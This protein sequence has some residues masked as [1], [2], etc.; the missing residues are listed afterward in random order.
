MI[1]FLN[2]SKSFG[3][4]KVL[5]DLNLPV[6]D[7]KIT[8]IM[9]PSGSGKSV[10]LKLLMGFIKPDHGSILFD[11]QDICAMNE[12]ALNEARQK[13]GILFQEAALFDYMNVF[14]NVSFPLYEHTRLSDS[15]IYDKV[16]RMLDEVG[17]SNI[18]HK[19]PSELS[20][21]MKKRVGL[22]RALMLDPKVILFDEPTTGLDPIT[23]MQIGDLIL[24]TQKAR[25]ATVILVNHD[26]SLTYRVADHVGMLYNGKIVELCKPEHLCRSKHPFVQQFLEAQS[27]LKDKE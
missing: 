17:L 19:Y 11:Q 22:A 18:L 12:H 21:G 5:D 1:E 15:M 6:L 3:E 26:L 24:K 14:E 20:G 10:T 16:N 23:T 13:F 7:G 9:G 8:V 4:Q 27:T 2:I 25:Q